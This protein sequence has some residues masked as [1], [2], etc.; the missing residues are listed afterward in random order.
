MPCYRLSL[1]M[2]EYFFVLSWRRIETV[3]LLSTWIMEVKH[4]ESHIFL[5]L[6]TVLH[7]NKLTHTDLKPE[8]ILFVNS[9]FT[10]SYNVEKVRHS[11]DIY[12]WFQT[13]QQKS[14]TEKPFFSTLLQITAL[15]SEYMCH[16]GFSH[17]TYQ[18]KH[19]HCLQDGKMYLY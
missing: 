4:S 14:K 10:M 8:N 13:L 11:L 17:G 9:D 7:D 18:L 19:T 5:S 6:S 12:L 2:L 15:S 3:S 1:P 16:A